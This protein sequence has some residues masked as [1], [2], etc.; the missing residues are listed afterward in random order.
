MTDDLDITKPPAR[1]TA[2]AKAQWPAL[3]ESLRRAITEELHSLQSGY[4][5][6]KADA[7]VARDFD[8]AIEDAGGPEWLQSIGFES[9]I[10]WLR[11][12]VEIEQRGLAHVN[13]G[14]PDLLI[15]EICHAI[16]RDPIEVFREAL[17]RREPP[18]GSA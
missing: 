7:Q 5:K 10:D 1:F 4:Y 6:T 3:P 12:R 13:A 15:A 14:R 17:S 18:V 16:G 2:D 9:P 11:S 8:K